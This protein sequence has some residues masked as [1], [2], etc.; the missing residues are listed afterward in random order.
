MIVGPPPG[1]GVARHAAH[2][3]DEPTVPGMNVLL[4]NQTFHPDVAATAQHL[5]DLARHLAAN[6]HRVTVVTGRSYYGTDR[7][8]EHPREMIEGIDIHRVR[9]S[10]LGKGSTLRRLT[11]F[12]TFYAAAALRVARLEAPDVIVALTSPPMIALIGTLTKRRRT[13]KGRHVRFVYYVMDVYPDAQVASGMLRRG[14]LIERVLRAVTGW[15]LR[16]ADGIIVLGRDMRQLLLERYGRQASAERIHIVRPWADATELRFLEKS[17]NALAERTGTH[18]VFTVV[19][20]GNFGIAHDVD[21]IVGAIHL[22]RD[23]P[24]LLWLFIGAGRRIQ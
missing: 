17:R 4:L 18:R 7:Q 22:T 19:H 15:T 13:A 11:D 1:A 6:G 10:A 9:G 21:T 24:G 16:S 8:H 12:A 23:E 14:S 5:W 20:S 2:L 3:P